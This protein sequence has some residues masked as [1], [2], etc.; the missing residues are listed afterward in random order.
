VFNGTELL[1]RMAMERML[2][3][4]STRRYPTAL[5]PVGEAV[6]EE[7]KSTSKSAVSRKFVKL[8]ETALADLLAVDLSGLDLVALMI[9]GVHFADHLCV[10]ALGIDIDG[11]KH[12]LA[13]VEGSTE[14][15]TLVRGLLVGL[16]VGGLTLGKSLP[17]LAAYFGD[18]DWRSATVATSLL[19]VLGG[20]LVLFVKLGPHHA[21]SPR[22]EPWAIRIAWTNPRIR[23][24]YVGYLGH[25]WELYAMWAWIAAAA[26]ASYAVTMA[27][28]EAES[29]AKLTAFLAVA[30]GGFACIVAGVF[31]DRVGKAEVAISAM[32]VSGAAAVL[33]ALSFGGP[34]WLTFVLILIWGIAVIPDSAQFSAI[35]ADNTPPHLAGS[36]LTFQTALGFGLTIV[37]VQVVPVLAEAFGWPAVIAVM[38]IGPAVGIVAMLPLRKQALDVPS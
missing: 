17:Y 15:T 37:T 11:T 12:P 22:F 36:L 19:A 9:D 21:P 6:S 33:T 2:A 7:S 23:R 14:N 32:A 8:T 38:A 4:V 25:M 20:L 27:Q 16:L 5:E 24:A 18:T 30:L 13:V 10:V 1:G 26:T 35:V 34:V 31:A 29:L 3:G 28:T